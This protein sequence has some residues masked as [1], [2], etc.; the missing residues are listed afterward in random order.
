M[1]D[2]GTAIKRPFQDIK[3][4]IIG[5]ILGAIPIVNILTIPGFALRNAKKSLE[6]DDS[7]LSWSNFGDTIVKSILVILI[8]VI[9]FLPVMLLFA[10]LLGAYIYTFVTMFSSSTMG[11]TGYATLFP[12][13]T[14]PSDAGYSQFAQTL[15]AM[16]GMILI[17]GLILLFI[18][19]ILPM[20]IM[21]WLKE[22]NFGAAFRLGSIIKK[23]FTGPYII[24]W[25]F[26]IIIVIIFGIIAFIL[27]FI[28]VIGG[29]IGSALLLYTVTV[30]QYTLFAQAYRELEQRERT[31]TATT[32]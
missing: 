14:I 25:I 6:G 2:F 28:P 17:V 27:G 29:L 1:V 20:A 4:L 26:T 31:A 9:Y 3:T 8:Q 21:H 24:A 16:F 12:L 5:I 10:I 32:A 23:S 22:D 11:A 19:F 7:L 15:S 13:A 30:S 18:V